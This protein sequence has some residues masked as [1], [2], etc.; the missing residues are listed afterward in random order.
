VASELMDLIIEC[1]NTLGW[2]PQGEDLWKARA[3]QVYILRRAMA[4]QKYT[5]R[6]VR[7]AIAWCRHEG[8]QVT[9]AAALLVFVPRARELA[10]VEPVNASTLDEHQ[11]AAIAWENGRSDEDSQYWITRLVRSVGSVRREVLSEWTEAGRGC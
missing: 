4:K 9:S 7:L 8:K 11:G 3:L 10:V 2:H 6:D 1:E 5:V